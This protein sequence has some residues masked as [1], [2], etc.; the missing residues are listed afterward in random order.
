MFAYVVRRLIGGVFLLL[1]VSLVTFVLFFAGPI[2]PAKFTCGKQCTPALIEQ[3]TKALGYD[4]PVLEQWGTYV[5]GIVKGRDFP[6]DPALK[7]TAPETI[8]HCSA[9]CLGYSPQTSQN[10]TTELQP[11]IPVSVS[12][13]IA[14]FIMWMIIGVG[15]GIIA[16]LLRGSVIDKALVGVSLIFYA[17]PTV[18]TG[19]LLYQF[20]AIKWQLVPAPQ[21]VPFSQSPVQWLQGLFLPAL[22]LALY[23]AAGYV[24]LTRAFIL[25]TLGEDYLR[26]AKAKGVPRVRVLFR[27]T[28]RAALTPIVT[29]AGLDLGALLG[30]AIITEQIF[31][32]PGLGALAV[33]SANQYDLPTT[34]GIVLVVATFIIIANL[35]VDV[36]YGL[37]DPR[38]KLA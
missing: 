28:L 15:A 27:H 2:N 32:Y 33:S 9:P 23:Y 34:I 22:T 29:Q 30:G 25:E 1:L 17:M 36:L 37:I 38:V 7:K 14:A 12:L 26:T 18:V 8:A 19:L 35:V 6:D 21:Y 16:A 20:V 10:V 4:K 5:V 24:R 31:S 3:N 13:A 11:R